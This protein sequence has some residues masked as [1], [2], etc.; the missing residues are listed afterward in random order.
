MSALLALLLLAGVADD[1]RV[2]SSRS[3]ARAMLIVD[4]PEQPVSIRPGVD[5]TRSACFAVPAGFEVR[6]V[7]TFVGSD[8]GNLVEADVQVYTPGGYYLIQRS[9]HREAPGLYDAWRTDA[10]DEAWSGPELCVSILGRSTDGRP[11]RL[12]WSVRL[13]GRAR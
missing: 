2:T 1:V 7:A 13:D 10:L 3:G 9:E 4:W 12:H 6:R 11:V 8:R 5:Y